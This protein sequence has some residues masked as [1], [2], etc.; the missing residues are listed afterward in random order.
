[1][2][3]ATRSHRRTESDSE[4]DDEDAAPADAAPV[5]LSWVDPAAVDS[6]V[7]VHMND[8]DEPEP[9]PRVGGH[10]RGDSATDEV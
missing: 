6:G 10:G 5:A 7:A 8:D 2:A 1:V 9:L 4:G 3:S